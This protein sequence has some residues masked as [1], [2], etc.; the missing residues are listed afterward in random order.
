MDTGHYL[1]TDLE[2]K[3]QEEAVET[4]HRMLDRQEDMIPYIKG[5]HLQQAVPDWGLCEGVVADAPRA[6]GGS[7]GTVPQSL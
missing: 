3:T 4:L 7:G 5:I 6:S 2:L 1:H